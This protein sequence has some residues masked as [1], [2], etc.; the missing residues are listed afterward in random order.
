MDVIS[1]SIILF[2]NNI[3]QI[4]CIILKFD[5]NVKNQKKMSLV[6]TTKTLYELIYDPNTGKF[7]D[8]SPFKKYDRSTNHLEYYCPC[9]VNSGFS[10]WSGWDHHVKLKTHIEYR[11]NYKFFNKPLLDCRQI[12]IDQKRENHK[13]EN[14]YKGLKLKYKTKD[15]DIRTLEGEKIELKNNIK[16]ISEELKMMKEKYESLKKDME[17]INNSVISDSDDEYMT[18]ENID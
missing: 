6:P 1:I 16:S 8:V 17:E 18:D 12:I 11:E 15:N 3:S 4:C 10:I 14:K 9:K 13:L 5:L 2:I 7:I